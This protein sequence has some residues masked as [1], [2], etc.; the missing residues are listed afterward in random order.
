MSGETRSH[1]TVRQELLVVRCQLG[2]RE[3]FDEL[4][5]R[6][7]LPIWR[8]VRRLLGREEEAEEV[9]QEVWLRILR[10]ILALQEP[11]RLPAWIF[12]IAR[13]TVMDRLRVRYA[14]A[15]LVPLE[16]LG[17]EEPDLGWMDEEVLE[18]ALLEL[19]PMEREVLVLFHL[20]ELTLRE[21]AEVLG[22]P[23]G[24]VK[25]RLSRARL[26]LEQRLREKGAR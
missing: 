1:E 22:V 25:S 17:A 2:E 19:S 12:T 3:A 10:G 13:R 4:A 26:A 20:R 7:H 21:V 23:T 11:G 16:E 5:E 9:T 6:W 18:R 24:T 14:E 8:Y 15:P